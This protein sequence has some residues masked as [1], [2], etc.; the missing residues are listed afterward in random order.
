MSELSDKWIY[1]WEV[2]PN[3]V[4][5]SFINVETPKVYLDAYVQVDIKYLEVKN[6]LKELEDLNQNI[7][8]VLSD[9]YDELSK[10]L[11]KYITAKNKIL[12]LMNVKQY[13]IYKDAQDITL[14][15]NDLGE[16]LMFFSS[17]KTTIGYN[18]INYDSYLNDYILLHGKKYSTR[19][20][21]NHNNIHIC[22]ELKNVSNNIIQYS[23]SF[24]Y[25]H[26]WIPSK[27][28]RYFTD[29]DIQKIL[30]LDA[31]YV[32]LKSVAINL[33]WHRIQELPIHFN[34][35]IESNE[36]YIVKDYNIN[37]ILITYTLYH[38]Q[39]EEVKLRDKVSERYNL[40]LR[41]DSRSSIGKKL[42]ASYYSQYSGLNY[43]DFKD[44]RTNRGR[45]SL[46]S[47]ITPRIYFKTNKFKDFL[48]VMLSDVVSPG[49]D[50]ERQLECNGTYY[51]I[52]KG[53]LHSIDDSRIYDAEK[54]KCKYLDADVTSYYPSI[55]L[56]FGI[57]PHHLNKTIFLDLV[58]L[59]RDDRVKAKD[60]VKKLKK[61]LKTLDSKD[62][63]LKE[64]IELLNKYIEDYN[65]EAEALK[66][67]INRIYGALRAPDDFLYDPRATY[68]TTFNG[69]LSLLMLIE[70]LEM[71]NIHIIS[72]NTDGIV[73]R[74]TPDKEELYYSLC[75][76]WEMETEFQLEFTEYEK[77]IR[78][79]VNEYVAVK[80][81]FKVDYDEVIKTTLLNTDEQI[82]AIKKLE[83]T[84]VKSKGSYIDTTDFNKGFVHPI[85]SLALKQ[86]VLYNVPYTETIYNHISKDKFNIYDYCISQKVDKKF[87][88][89]YTRVRKGE[90]I[91]VPVQQ[92]NRFYI[93]QRNGGTIVK[94]Y[95]YNGKTRSQQLIANKQI[96]LFNDYEERENYYVDYRFYIHKVEDFLYFKGKNSKG[97]H[98]KE[99]LLV[100]S[101]NLFS[102]QDNDF[103]VSTDY[104]SNNI[105][106]EPIERI[107]DFDDN[108]DINLCF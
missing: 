59:F 77:Y 51:R 84:Y 24:G 52:A 9:E 91:K 37:D 80:K 33:K 101:H 99:G 47:I 106:P 43:R 25:R 35:Y 17:H 90:I 74:V 28:K 83:E 42:M 46:S 12:E 96:A 38:N 103:G 87:D 18:S 1:D 3:F 68:M 70:K 62:E 64:K 54:D 108:A 100:R 2:Y 26:D 81:G 56:I 53:G 34:K 21:F 23:D 104:V 66:I 73:C 82:T 89:V 88:V 41:N 60:A 72:A 40:N 57:Y 14:D 95:T 69:Q 48:R 10:E 39:I 20:G 76:E 94:E 15:I 49:E 6:K 75:K 92:Y 27:Y 58:R 45:M 63:V 50:Y 44:L 30:Y 79:N 61:V 86:Y 13:T 11:Y 78:N 8:I 7:D 31:T 67:V 5:V 97:N 98:K 16:L 32:G 22:N 105:E 107:N 71:N 36:V 93:T 85:V 102:D 4:C 65:L 29:Y 55:L 19:T